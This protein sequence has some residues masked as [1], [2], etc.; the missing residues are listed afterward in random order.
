LH[1]GRVLFSG[2]PAE[3]ANDP[4]VISAYLGTETVEAPS[5]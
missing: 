5:A 1:E 4:M 3:V 2:L